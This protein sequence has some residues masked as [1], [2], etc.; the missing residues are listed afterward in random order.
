MAL[1]AF[2]L[3][4]WPRA[5]DTPLAFYHDACAQQPLIFDIVNQ[6]SAWLSSKLRKKQERP[7]LWRL[8]L[9]SL[10]INGRQIV[11]AVKTIIRGQF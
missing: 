2:K 10:S 3:L 1:E 5:V 6:T 7:I 11:A 4:L 9:A 8:R